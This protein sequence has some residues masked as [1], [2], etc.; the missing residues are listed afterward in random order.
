[1][2]LPDYLYNGINDDRKV[3]KLSRV[4]NENRKYD[5]PVLVG[6]IGSIIKDCYTDFSF[7]VVNSY[8][9]AFL[10]SIGVNRVTLSQEL[11][12]EEIK[13]LIENLE[14]VSSYIPMNIFKSVYNINLNTIIGYHKDD[15]KYNF[16]DDY[17]D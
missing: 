12:D 2:Y 4:Q 9:V 7:N 17:D 16:L 5:T 11:N 3:L 15:M 10:H 6:E 8:T 14:K 13:E 1:M